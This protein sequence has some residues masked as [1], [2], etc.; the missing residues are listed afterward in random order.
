[1]E[2]GVWREGIWGSGDV[3]KSGSDRRSVAKARFES[4]VMAVMR[5]DRNFVNMVEMGRVRC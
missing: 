5:R 3:Q 4:R 1:M 2:E